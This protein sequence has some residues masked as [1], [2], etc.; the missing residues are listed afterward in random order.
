MTLRM[1]A[2]V[3]VLTG[4]LTGCATTTPYDYTAFRESSPRSILVLPPVNESLDTSASYSFLTHVSLPLAE[5]GYYVFPVAVVEETFRENGLTNPEEIHSLGLDR[6]NEVFGADSVMYIKITRYGTSYQLL[7]SDTRVT[8]EASLVDS[9]SGQLL[10]KGQATASSTEQN[11]NSGGG[12]VGLLV[13]ALVEQVINSTTDR[14][15]QIAGMTSGRLLSAH[16]VNG[17]LP[18]PRLRDRQ[19]Q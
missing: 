10:W 17:V 2:V 6:L 15:Y 9:R 5:A 18:G 1:M 11:N 14:S 7:A 16:A 19:L 3:A 4:L 8:A 12:L 13:V